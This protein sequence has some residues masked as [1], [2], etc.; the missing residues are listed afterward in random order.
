[1]NQYFKFKKDL[2]VMP[3]L[4]LKL[5]ILNSLFGPDEFVSFNMTLNLNFYQHCLSPLLIP[6]KARFW[7][8]KLGIKKLTLWGSWRRRAL[9]RSRRGPWCW[10]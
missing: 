2:S 4:L 5:L 7:Q 8:P 10:L 9:S 1:M 3:E 6:A